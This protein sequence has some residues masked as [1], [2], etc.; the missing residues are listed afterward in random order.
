MGQPK[1]DRVTVEHDRP[2]QIGHR[3]VDF[4]EVVNGN[5]WMLPKAVLN[6]Y[7]AVDDDYMLADCGSCPPGA[8]DEGS[9]DVVVPARNISELKR[10]CA[11]RFGAIELD[12]AGSV[13][14]AGLSNDF[15]CPIDA[16]G[17]DMKANCQVRRRE[18]L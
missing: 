17:L 3:Q 9:A 8:A 12:A 5:H 15:E 18:R 7:S 1:A 16:I 14:L 13:V 10:D 11:T 2:L 6:R 4:K